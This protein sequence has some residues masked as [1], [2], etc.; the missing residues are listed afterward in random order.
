[1]TDEKIINITELQNAIKK[2]HQ[3]GPK[4]VAVSSTE[5]NDKLTA[6]VSTEKGIARCLTS[7]IITKLHY[8][9]EYILMN[10]FLCR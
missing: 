9:N 3:I 7:Q 8:N 6:V 4:T 10:I 5:L 1:M 2:L